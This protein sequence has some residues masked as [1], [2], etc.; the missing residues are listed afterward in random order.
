VVQNKE[1]SVYGLTLA[2]SGVSQIVGSQLSDTLP[3]V[4]VEYIGIS[5]LLIGALIFLV[6]FFWKRDP[7]RKPLGI[8][9]LAVS[10]AL[11]GLLFV[12]L[13]GWLYTPLFLL[14]FA[15]FVLSYGLFAAKS[16]ALIGVFIF[17]IVGL[18]VL[19]FGVSNGGVVNVAGVLGSCYLFWYIDREHVTKYFKTQSMLP[20][21]SRGSLKVALVVVLLFLPLIGYL[22]FNPPSYVASS[23]WSSGSGGPGGE[24]HTFTKGDLVTCTFHVVSGY[25]PAT[26]VISSGEG[27]G[28]GEIIA[29]DTGMSG[30]FKGTVPS[31]GTYTLWIGAGTGSYDVDYEI[32]VTLYSMRRATP[33]WAL[34]DVYAVM[35]LLSAILATSVTAPV[36]KKPETEQHPQNIIDLSVWFQDSC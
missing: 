35:A 18:L 21:P 12:F 24:E 7:S 15:C 32:V 29:S 31:T 1:V 27:Y 5:V 17:L 16:W 22:H 20:R 13:G 10:Y 34:L 9:L 33:Q 4:L 19:L 23:G 14:G 3:V 11:A 28:E 36:E 30:S 26:I 2:A 8:T 25:P 6:G